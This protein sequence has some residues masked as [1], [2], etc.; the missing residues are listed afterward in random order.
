MESQ[1]NQNKT[2]EPDSFLSTKFAK[3]K[4]DAVL[5]QLQEIV[6]TNPDIGLECLGKLVKVASVDRIKQVIATLNEQLDLLASI[7]SESVTSSD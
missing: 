6:E 5:K 1:L 3:I 4:H 7:K 2:L